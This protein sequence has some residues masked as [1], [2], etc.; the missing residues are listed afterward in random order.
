MDPS[1]KVPLARNS[2]FLRVL[3]AG[4][5]SSAGASLAGVCL[6]WLVYEETGSAAAVAALAIAQT[7]ATVL[8]SLPAGTWTDRYDRRRM[9][10]TTDVILAIAMASIGLLFWKG[11]FDLPV[12]VAVTAVVAGATTPFNTAEQ[13]FL[14]SIV[15]AAQVADANGLV[16]TTRSTVGF[17]GAA[18]A[19]L[20]ILA[21]GAPVGLLLNALTYAVSAVLILSVPVVAKPPAA[22]TG[23]PT[24]PANFWAETIEGVRWLRGSPGFLW[25]TG[26][27]LFLNFFLT[28]VGPFLV[29][30]VGVV[31]HANA[32]VFG[33]ISA[34]FA[35]GDVVGALSVG[36]SGSSAFAGKAWLLGYG[37]VTGGSII[38]LILVPTPLAA[39]VL[40]FLGGWGLGFAGTSWLSAAQLLVPP[41]IQGRYFGID[42]LGS[43]AITPLGA[44]A[45]A[46]LIATRGVQFTF[47]AAGAGCVLT[48]VVFATFRDLWRLGVPPS[49]APLPAEATA[50]DR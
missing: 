13:V 4:T 8:V 35:V 28:M 46:A 41:G 37:G 2:R 22:T 45:G 31:L 33:A 21:V 38:G 43:S 24:R 12:A 5:A 17:L 50:G 14:P 10:I 26:S 6:L 47:L 7:I 11:S 40:T 3:T 25:L 49:G 30:Y 32:L 34:S 36:R 9:M 18:G 15:S 39:V 19:G 42:A 1:P 23:G 29:V 16:R 48:L 20:L 27:A 44:V